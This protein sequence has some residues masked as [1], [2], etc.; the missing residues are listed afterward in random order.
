MPSLFEEQ[1]LHEEQELN[2]LYEMQVGVGS[3]SRCRTSPSRRIIRSTPQ[4]YLTTLAEAKRKVCHPADRQ[5]ERLLDGRLDAATPS[6]MQDAGADALELNIYFVPTDPDMTA[7]EVERRYIDLVASVRKTCHDPAGGEDR[8]ELQQHPA[9][10]P[11]T[12]HRRGPTGWCCST[13]GWSRTSTWK[14]SRSRRISC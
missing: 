11:P 10:C 14:N 6:R 12:G 3:P 8:Y 4:E 9:L 1:I 2:R 7:A 13:A 5:P